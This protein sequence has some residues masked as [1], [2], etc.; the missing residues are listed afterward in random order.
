MK[1]N[2]KAQGLGGFLKVVV[3]GLVFLSTF[4]FL[5]EAI[6]EASS[7]QSGLTSTLIFGI[8]FVVLWLFLRFAWTLGEDSEV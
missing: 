8:L 7:Q 1:L 2:K 3:I 6:N 5:Y 4:P